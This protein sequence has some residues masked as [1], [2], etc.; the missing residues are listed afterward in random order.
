MSTSAISSAADF[1]GKL[2]REGVSLPDVEADND[3]WITLEW[4]LSSDN[5]V[6]V[7]I[8]PN[9]TGAFASLLEGKGCRGDF[10][11]DGKSID[12]RVMVLLRR[13]ESVSVQS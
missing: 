7:S 1:L 6:H 11:T 3:G 12:E 5:V 9:G 13:F 4:Y 2:I 8:G 10:S